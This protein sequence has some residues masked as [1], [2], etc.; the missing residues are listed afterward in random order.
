MS[1]IEIMRTGLWSC[2]SMDTLSS[3]RE[4]KRLLN[5][6]QK[7]IYSALNLRGSRA[8]LLELES[9]L[10]LLEFRSAENCGLLLGEGS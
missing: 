7:L 6:A 3:K 2:V 10:K 9:A 5:T 8:A 1:D 4:E